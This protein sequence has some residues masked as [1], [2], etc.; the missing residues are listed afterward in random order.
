MQKIKR[1]VL[2]LLLI[3][4]PVAWAWNSN[5]HRIIAQIAYENL[6]AVAKSHIDNLTRGFDRRYGARSRFLF[7]AIWPDKIKFD[8][9]S[10]FDDWHFINYGFSLDHT[11]IMPVQTENVVWAIGQSEHTLLSP[12][13]SN[14][15]KAVALNFLIHFVGD[16]HQPLHCTV[17]YSSQFP[18]GDKNGLLFPINAADVNNLHSYWDEGLGLFGNVANHSMP[19]KKINKLADHIQKKYP[20]SFFGTKIDDLTA[21]HWAM[22]SFHIAANVAYSNIAENSTP[23]AQYKKNGRN[24]VEQQI[25]LAGYRLAN[26]LDELFS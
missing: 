8:G 12:N 20:K 11:K 19:D 14:R 1:I 10:A 25:A 7:A 21:S 26:V 24:I 13:A 6:N 15:E 2:G 16:V 3:L 23:S 17:R 4:P 18:A 22:Q 9:V 5:G